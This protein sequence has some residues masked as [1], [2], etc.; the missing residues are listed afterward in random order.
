MNALN[1]GAGNK[2][3]ARNVRD[4]G[5]LQTGPAFSAALD[6]IEP[7]IADWP[8]YRRDVARSGY[9]PHP[10]PGQLTQ[11]WRAELAGRLSALVV[12]NGLV[13]V[14]QIDVHTVHALDAATG[15]RRWSYTAGAR[16]DSPPTYHQGRIV[17]G[18]ADGYIYCLRAGDG[19]LIWRFRAAPAERRMMAFEQI[20]SV[21]PVHGSVLVEKN[22]VSAIAGR[23]SFLDG[24]MRLIR[25]DLASGK[26]LQ[27]V[28]LDD[29][30]PDTGGD[31]QERLQTLQM[32]VGLSDI[33]GSDGQFTFLRSQRFDKDGRRLDLG[34]I[35]GNAA[36]QGGAQAGE[37]RHLFA[38]MGF[39]DDT[40]FHR[41]YWIY[42][43]N[44]AGGHNGYFQAG[45]F[46]PAGQMLV[47]SADRV[48]GFGRLPEYLKW[49]TTMEHQLFATSKDA[50][51]V[52]AAAKRSPAAKGGRAG[53][54]APVEIAT[55]PALDPTGKELTV[56]AWIM[57]ETPNGVILAHGG[58]QNGYALV[59]DQRRPSFVI[60]ADS[61]LAVTTSPVPISQGWNHLAGTLSKDG[62]L[63]V[64]VNGRGAAS[65]RSAKLIATLPKQ[66]LELA[67]DTAGSVGAYAVTSFGG[68][69][70]E[71]R[72]YHVALSEEQLTLSSSS[73][74]HA[75][76]RQPKPVLS[77]TFD[78][79]DARDQSG[80]ENHGKLGQ[81]Q[82]A[83]GKL[84][85]ALRARVTA[86][87][88]GGSF[89]QMQWKRTVPLFARAMALTG[90]TL[91]VAGPRDIQ[92]EEESFKRLAQSDPEVVKLLQQ[93]DDCM[94]GKN[95]SLL[96]AVD[97]KDGTTRQEIQLSHLPA[98]DGMAVAGNRIL[99]ATGDGAVNC[100][101][102]GASE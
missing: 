95:G 29:V 12:A 4:E 57:P 72:V 18:S 5:R 83:D 102:A 21:W 41:A 90:D 34:P 30:D 1:S 39:L 20:E 15:K 2:E 47:S 56:E 16:V 40:Y 33:L 101:V 35:S 98:W 3:L 50:P 69:I 59:L 28:I 93:Q 96:L 6:E 14:A 77:L 75:R 66:P 94:E 97:V 54:V 78:E 38:P 74:E 42:G 65:A 60:R 37:F 73:P 49:T 9:N 31:L 64:F 87:Q 13:Y 8:T 89:V 17:F 52:P 61:Q 48:F 19:Q 85:K 80:L 91:F 44:F 32:P 43:R 26:K 76:G 25:L 51:S 67:N 45:K 84:G 86:N 88:A 24:G 70:D 63:R 23:S 7:A 81:A 11:A 22:I 58:P 62:T 99:I 10:V 71:V 100:F 82:F 27:E 55:R 68:L 46:T 53:I 36:E 92:N 79:A